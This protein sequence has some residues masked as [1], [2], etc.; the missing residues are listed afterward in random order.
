MEMHNDGNAQGWKYSR[1]ER[2][3]KQFEEK[4]SRYSLFDQAKSRN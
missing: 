3:M 2:C 4:A 1:M